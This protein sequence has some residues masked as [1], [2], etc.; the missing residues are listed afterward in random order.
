M[1]TYG[2]WSYNYFIYRIYEVLNEIAEVNKETRF[3]IG[4][5]EEGLRCS[6]YCI[7]LSYYPLLNIVHSCIAKDPKRHIYPTQ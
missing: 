6:R 2:E 5:S 3:D 4:H 7:L 1:R